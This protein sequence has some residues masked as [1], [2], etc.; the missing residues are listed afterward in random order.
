LSVFLDAE[1]KSLIAEHKNKAARHRANCEAMLKRG[2]DPES[3]QYRH[4]FEAAEREITIAEELYAIWG[5]QGR[6]DAPAFQPRTLTT[7]GDPT[8]SSE[9]RAAFSAYLNR[10]R[11]GVDGYMPSE[12]LRTLTIASDPDGGYTV[13]A[14]RRSELVK[15][16]PALSPLLALVRRPPTSRDMV[17]WVRVEPHGSSPDIYTS[18]FVGGMVGEITGGG[19]AQ[20]EFG[21]LE[22]PIKKSRA[23]C[24]FSIDLAADSE[25]DMGGF[26]MSDGA[27]NLAIVRE[28][29]I[30]VGSGVGNNCRGVLLDSDIATVDVEGTT[31]NS[32]SNTTSDMGSVLKLF[33]LV[34]A[35]PA[36]YRNDPSFRWVMNP[37]TGKAILKLV[38]GDGSLLLAKLRAELPEFVYSEHMPVGGVDGNKIILAGPLSQIVSPERIAISAQILV[39]R[40]AD[41]D[42]LAIVLRSRFGVGVMNPRAFRFG[43]V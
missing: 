3:E 21:T 8:S 18:A 7:D 23:T 6:G 22:I 39:E 2:I 31:A 34:Y 5:E 36:Q 30:L 28:G 11:R 14:D 16:L 41:T 10:Y 37:Q 17:T 1:T 20:P 43:I 24:R 35:V 12:E 25:Q 32:I 9:Y 42:E 40:Y 29:Q 38:D 13:P 33:D 4:E 26:L 15:Q 27:A 19:D